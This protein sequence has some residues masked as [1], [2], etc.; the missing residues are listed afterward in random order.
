MT[1][2]IVATGIA[3]FLALAARFP[4]HA[5]QATKAALHE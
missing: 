1:M 4:R 5:G 3:A 2:I